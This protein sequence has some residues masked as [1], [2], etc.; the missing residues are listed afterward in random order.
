MHLFVLAI[1]LKQIPAPLPGANS[2]FCAGHHC[3]KDRSAVTSITRL[4]FKVGGER[5][6]YGHKARTW[7]STCKGV[8]AFF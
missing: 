4:M 5:P 3:A 7:A 1:T 8:G 2:P 6:P